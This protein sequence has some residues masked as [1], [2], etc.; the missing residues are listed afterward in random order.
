MSRITPIHYKKLIRVFEEAGFHVTRTKG[1]HV[2][3]VKTKN[4]RPLVI[5][6]REDVPV[7]VIKNNMRSAGLTR[8]Q[9][10]E[11]LAKV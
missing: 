3:M 9:Y 6:E 1:D 10:F 4:P 7:F 8:E 2:V 5:P 11:L